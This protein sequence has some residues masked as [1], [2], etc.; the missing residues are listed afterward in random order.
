MLRNIRVLSVVMLILAGFV[1]TGCAKTKELE[2]INKQ[3]AETIASLNSEVTKLNDELDAMKKAKE[4]LEKAKASLE[5]KLSKEVAEGGLEIGMEDRGLVVTMLDKILFDPGKTTIK[6]QAQGVL[7]KVADIL[8]KN[9]K[10]NIVYVEGHTDSD[11][12]KH[13]G[14]RSNWEL[15]T[16]RSTEVVHYFIDKKDVKPERLIACGY[17]EF[18][19][20]ASNKTSAGKSKNRRV[21]V[22]IS[23][24][25]YVEK[26]LPVV[27]G[28]AG[29]E[30]TK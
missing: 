28:E 7:D 6:T 23:P 20:V 24:K 27:Q 2:R 17:G 16:A 21:E 9:V 26:S 12:I 18:Q 25:K 8:K 19:P 3:Q 1:L 29:E 4:E 15:S 11:P 14:Y 22:I 13:S 30:Y 10:D 5:Q